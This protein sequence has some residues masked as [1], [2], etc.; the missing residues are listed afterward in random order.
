MRKTFLTLALLAGFTSMSAQE[1][2]GKKSS[3]NLDDIEYNVEITIPTAILKGTKVSI[4]GAKALKFA[5]KTT[6]D[7]RSFDAKNKTAWIVL[8]KKAGFDLTYTDTQVVVLEGKSN[9]SVTTLIFEK[10]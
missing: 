9:G 3:F 10:Q 1:I 4:D 2:T 5:K 7:G 8:F 6:K